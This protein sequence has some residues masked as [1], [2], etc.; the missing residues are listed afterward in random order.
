MPELSKAIASNSN[1]NICSLE[2]FA[3]VSCG[4]GA[5]D[6]VSAMTFCAPF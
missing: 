3:G 2:R 6:R 4:T 1:R 5:L